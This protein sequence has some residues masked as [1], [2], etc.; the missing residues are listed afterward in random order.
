MRKSIEERTAPDGG[1]HLGIPQVANPTKWFYFIYGTS[2]EH[3]GSV[4]LNI[5]SSSVIVRDPSPS[6]LRHFFPAQL[7]ALLRAF[8]LWIEEDWKPRGKPV[9]DSQTAVNVEQSRWIFALLAH[10][11]E[12]LVGDDISTL[13]SLA[14]S[15]I[16]RIA[17]LRQSTTSQPFSFGSESGAWILICAIAGTWAQH[18]LWSEA[19]AMLST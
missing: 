17:A 4:G 11:D 16:M 15:C 12:R 14:R 10:I 7:F 2:A 6:L 3:Q 5:S 9:E 8:T 1:S 18:D 19:S 13:R